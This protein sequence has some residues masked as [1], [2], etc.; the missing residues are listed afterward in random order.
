MAKAG[1]PAAPL[2]TWM[3][4]SFAAAAM[5]ALLMSWAKGVNE[6][7]LDVGLQATARLSFLL[8]C[9]AFVGSPLA[10]LFGAPFG[11]LKARGR[12]LGLAFAS[13]HLVHLALVAGLCLIGAAPPI[14]SFIL[15]GIAAAWTYILAALSTG[16]L[17]RR[18][19]HRLWRALR[20][21]GVGYIMCAFAVDFL[22]VKPAFGVKWLV[23]YLPF[24]LMLVVAVLL[25]A[26]AFISRQLTHIMPRMRE[27]VEGKR[28]KTID[29]I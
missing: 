18:L 29:A 27:D 11:W 28:A 19:S 10:T 23:A 9:C 1:R 26:G 3:V 12:Q 25:Y 4:S 7:G 2:A 20:T 16:S 22:R 21:I 13:A 24:Q 8:F 14:A 15:F 5:L 6:S 17:Q